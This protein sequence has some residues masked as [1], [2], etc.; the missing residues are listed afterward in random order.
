[1][2]ERISSVA[3][4]CVVSS[5]RNAPHAGSRHAG[6]AVRSRGTRSR[7]TAAAKGSEPRPLRG[8]S[9]VCFPVSKRCESLMSPR[10]RRRRRRAGEE[11][12]EEEEDRTSLEVGQI[13]SGST[14]C[15][16]TQRSDGGCSSWWC[17]CCW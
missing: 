5:G 12:E 3:G 14:G 8:Q 15:S 11:E 6:R 2:P 10:R 17:C 16:T 9:R 7:G 13:P 1:M 4:C